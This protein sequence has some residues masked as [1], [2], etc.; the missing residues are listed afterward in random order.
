MRVM[1]FKVNRSSPSRYALPRK[2]SASS[3][4]HRGRSLSSLAPARR[5]KPPQSQSVDAYL[6]ASSVKDEVVMKIPFVACWPAKAPANAIAVKLGKKRFTKPSEPEG[7]PTT[8]AQS[9]VQAVKP[10]TQRHAAIN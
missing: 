5:A 3:L 2:R 7:E 4:R 9:L 6:S 10:E 8:F 1:I